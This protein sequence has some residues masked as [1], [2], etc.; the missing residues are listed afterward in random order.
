[1]LC[2]RLWQL[3]SSAHAFRL[4]LQYM[5]STSVSIRRVFSIRNC[6]AHSVESSFL[7]CWDRLFLGKTDQCSQF[8]HARILGGTL[9]TNRDRLFSLGFCIVLYTETYLGLFSL[10]SIGLIP[11]RILDTYSKCNDLIRDSPLTTVLVLGICKIWHY[12]H[13]TARLRGEAGLPDLYDADDLPDPVY[14]KNYV[15]VLSEEEQIDLHYRQY[16]VSGSKLF[17]N[18]VFFQIN[19]CS[20]SPRPGIGHTVPRLTV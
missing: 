11:C 6:C 19:T 1:M 2:P 13:K 9:P 20:W 15:H 17:V 8:K 4:L 5:G 12:K 7:G 14:D 16:S 3:N 10:P 18:V